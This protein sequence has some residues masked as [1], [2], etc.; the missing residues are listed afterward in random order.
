MASTD[1]SLF[2]KNNFGRISL[3][4]N[5]SQKQSMNFNKNSFNVSKD[6][7]KNIINND[8]DKDIGNKKK[9]FLILILMKNIQ[10]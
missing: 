10:T 6:N 2:K 9:N 4:N 8:I 3:T 7:N 5:Y 1:S